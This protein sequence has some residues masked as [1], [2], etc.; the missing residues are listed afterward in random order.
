MRLLLKPTTTAVGFTTRRRSGIS[1][2]PPFIR[3]IIQTVKLVYGFLKHELAGPQGLQVFPWWLRIIAAGVFVNTFIHHL[4]D[5]NK[6]V[7]FY[8]AFGLVLVG[9]FLRMQ[10]EKS[11]SGRELSTY[12]THVKVARSNNRLVWILVAAIMFYALSAAGIFIYKNIYP[13][14]PKL[15]HGVS[16]QSEVRPSRNSN[17]QKEPGNGHTHKE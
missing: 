1:V 4:Y 12:E 15:G 5:K 10:S 14:K 7:W 3:W 11:A 6:N 8:I 2:T 16:V 17:Q 9:Q 13:K